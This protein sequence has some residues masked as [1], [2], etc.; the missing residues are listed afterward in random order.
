MKIIKGFEDCTVSNTVLFLETM[1]LFLE[2]YIF[3]AYFFPEAFFHH[4]A[5]EPAGERSTTLPSLDVRDDEN[6]VYSLLGEHPVYS[7]VV[8][9]K[10]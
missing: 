2:T 4:P 10:T 8:R 9:V 1:C 5:T 3:F 6:C 7:E